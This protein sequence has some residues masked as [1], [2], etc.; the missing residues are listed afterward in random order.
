MDSVREEVR[1]ELTGFERDWMKSESFSVFLCEVIES[2]LELE[3]DPDSDTGWHEDVEAECDATLNALTDAIMS[4]LKRGAGVECVN[5]WGSYDG[6]TPAEFLRRIAN[7][8]L[9]D[10]SCSDM[11]TLANHLERITSAVEPSEELGQILNPD[12]ETGTQTASE[13]LGAVEPSC[14][15][16]EMAIRA[17]R[18]AARISA[19]EN[20]DD[21]VD[22]LEEFSKPE[23]GENGVRDQIDAEKRILTAALSSRTEE[24]RKVP[25]YVRERADEEIAQIKASVARSLTNGG[26]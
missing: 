19:E 26:G 21:Y 3:Q 10:P 5:D 4:A 12:R 18:E 24:E 11:H 2:H 14:M 15:T 1:R 7:K 6:E 13:E 8:E 9:A 22:P 20:G 23:Y 25:A 16:D 17:L